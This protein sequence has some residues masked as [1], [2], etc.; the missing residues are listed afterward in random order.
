MDY[1]TRKAK[2]S[3]VWVPE[4]SSLPGAASWLFPSLA[5]VFPIVAPNGLSSLLLAFS[6]TLRIWRQGFIVSVEAKE[7]VSSVSPVAYF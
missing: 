6:S 7:E 3:L 4:N 1:A 5:L 2:A